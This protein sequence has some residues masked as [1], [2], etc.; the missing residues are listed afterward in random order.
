[1]SLSLF[2]RPQVDPT[3]TQAEVDRARALAALRREQDTAD[4]TARAD[5]ERA[6]REARRQREAERAERRAGRAAARRRLL[7]QAC[8]CWC[9]C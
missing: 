2:T 9:R 5:A 3:Q 6:A 4:R 8:G 7:G 1:M